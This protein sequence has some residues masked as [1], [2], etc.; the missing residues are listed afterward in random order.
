MLKKDSSNESLV[1]LSVSNVGKNR[2]Q[3]YIPILILLISI[4][5]VDIFIYRNL[6]NFKEEKEAAFAEGSE[7]A[8]KSLIENDL[9]LICNQYVNLD[10]LSIL[11]NHSHSIQTNKN[12]NVIG[13]VLCVK[14]NNSSIAFDLQPL[15]F[16]VNSIL[17]Q[18]FYYQVSFNS[19]ILATNI[20]IELFNYVRKYQINKESFLTIKLTPKIESIFLQKNLQQLKKHTLTMLAVST[21]LFL[22]ASILI[23]YIVN[24]QKRQRTLC[25]ARLAVEGAR[26][27][28]LLYIKSCQNLD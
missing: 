21:I 3:Y 10:Q 5:I 7:V 18:N 28:N 27:L 16:L 2:W 9:Q 23:I 17:A 11:K 4:I 19:Y 13:S 20:D 22:I 15:V 25:N 24:R 6:I 8:V 26:E 12:Y 14:Q 1:S